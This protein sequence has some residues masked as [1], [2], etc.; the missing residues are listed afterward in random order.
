MN[1]FSWHLR[2]KSDRTQW[3]IWNL[4][5]MFVSPSGYRMFF[6]LNENRCMLATLRKKY[7]HGFPWNIRYGSDTI[8]KWECLGNVPD[9][10]M[11]CCSIFLVYEQ[12]H[13]KHYELIFMK[14]TGW[15][16]QYTIGN[17]WEYETVS[18]FARLVSSPCSRYP[19]VCSLR[20]CQW[21]ILWIKDID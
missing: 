6:I 3:E 16:G 10:H 7:M 11:W 8:P 1:G 18:R 20:L 14:C 5:V 19:S 15:F 12:Q 13:G 2:D 21:S 9:H 17:L 4:L